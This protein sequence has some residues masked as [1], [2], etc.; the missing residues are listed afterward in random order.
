MKSNK[1]KKESKETLF[2]LLIENDEKKL[3]DFLLMNGKKKSY[4]PICFRK[5]PINSSIQNNND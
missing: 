3:Q 2:S 5:E 1:D 4:C